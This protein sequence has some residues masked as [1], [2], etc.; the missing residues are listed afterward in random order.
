[1]VKIELKNKKKG[2]KIT[3]VTEIIGNQHFSL[4]L[5]NGKMKNEG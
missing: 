2:K 4:D 5:V 1:M 3:P